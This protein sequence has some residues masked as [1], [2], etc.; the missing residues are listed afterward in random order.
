VYVHNTRIVITNNLI[1]S[2]IWVQ[3]VLS[4]LLQKNW[5]FL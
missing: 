5:R 2:L 3:F 1:I 4:K